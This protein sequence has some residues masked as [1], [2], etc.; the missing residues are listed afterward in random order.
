MSWRRFQENSPTFGYDLQ[1]IPDV[2]IQSECPGSHD[3][4]SRMCTLTGPL[5][6]P[7]ARKHRSIRRAPGGLLSSLARH[8]KLLT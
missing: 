3:S 8:I 6:L 4:E 2:P 7:R 5:W 1:L